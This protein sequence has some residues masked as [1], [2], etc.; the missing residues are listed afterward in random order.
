MLPQTRGTD[1]KCTLYE[2]GILQE[3]IY[4]KEK[5]HVHVR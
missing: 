1:E 3:H 4:I 2:K 5:V